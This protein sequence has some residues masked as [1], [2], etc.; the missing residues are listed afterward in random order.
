MAVE[1]PDWPEEIIADDDSLYR[2]VPP[3]FVKPDGTLSDK[4]FMRNSE[5]NR[6]KKEPDPDISVDWDRYATP[7]QSL[8]RA[9]RP[10]HGICGLRAAFPRSLDLTATHSPDR[11]HDNRAHASIRGNEGPRAKQRCFRLA[12]QASKHLLIRPTSPT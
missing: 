8:V 2:R 5:S 9:E 11:E 10:T 3:I 4:L 1:L 6:N 7:E 12:E